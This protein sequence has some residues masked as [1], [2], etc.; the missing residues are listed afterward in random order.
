MKKQLVTGLL[1]LS[2]VAG[3]VA[4][5][6][7]Q[8][9]A[10]TVKASSSKVSE[11]KVTFTNT[12][13][14]KKTTKVTLYKNDVALMNYKDK[15]GDGKTHPIILIKANVKNVSDKE[16]QADPILN[17]EVRQEV[18]K[19]VYK[20]LSTGIINKGDLPAAY[21]GLYE[22]NSMDLKP[23]ADTDVLLAYELKNNGNVEI[24]KYTKDTKV[25]TIK[26]ISKLQ[27]VAQAPSKDDV[28]ATTESDSS[29]E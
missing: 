23:G 6:N 22:N 24:D 21:Q 9:N 1:G 15:Y 11:G 16:R 20:G 27:H 12:V 3:V 5:V 28:A 29:A 4:P 19:G 18:K 7:A 13:A 25:T 2:L 17:L 8:V 14:G 26:G 10:K